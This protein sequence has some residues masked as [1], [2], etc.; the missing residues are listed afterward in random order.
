MSYET[1]S[2]EQIQYLKRIKSRN[3]SIVILRIMLF[4]VFLAVWKPLLH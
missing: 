1:F 3:R 2:K 4:V